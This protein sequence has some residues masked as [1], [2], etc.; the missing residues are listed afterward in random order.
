MHHDKNKYMQCRRALCLFVTKGTLLSVV[1]STLT[2]I[3]NHNDNGPHIGL[4]YGGAKYASDE[5]RLVTRR[6]YR[7][8]ARQ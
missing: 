1:S 8:C 7:L 6:L 4:C 2:K 5:D 3:E